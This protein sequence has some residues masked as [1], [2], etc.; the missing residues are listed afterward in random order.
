M[1][2]PCL[3]CTIRFVLLPFSLP[4]LQWSLEI[5]ENKAQYRVAMGP[6]NTAVISISIIHFSIRREEEILPKVLLSWQVW[7]AANRTQSQLQF[8]RYFISIPLDSQSCQCQHHLVGSHTIS[9]FRDKLHAL[10]TL[11]EED[12][13]YPTTQQIVMVKIKEHF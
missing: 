11:T 5:L 6:R 1:V 9:F 13:G 7:A 3:I 4:F 12:G 2:N 10:W 8:W